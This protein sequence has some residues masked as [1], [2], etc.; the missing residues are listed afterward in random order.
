M[1]LRLPVLLLFM[2]LVS[3]A[4][5]QERNALFDTAQRHWLLGEDNSTANHPLTA[6][7]RIEWN[8][9]AEGGGANAI[10]AKLED[11]FFNAGTSPNLSGD[12]CTVYLRASDPR[13]QWGTALLAKR[14]GHDTINFNLYSLP[15]TIGFEIH[16]D[17]GGF[18]GVTFPLSDI[19]P[20]AWHDF[21]GRYDGKTVELFCDGKVMAR[22]RW[23]GGMLTQNQEPL[24]IGAET[25]AG[26]TVRPFTG[27]MEEA[28][29]W[30][31]ALSNKELAT[32]MRKDKIIKPSEPPPPY[33]S[34]IHFRPKVGVLADTIPFFWKG[35]YHIFYLHGPMAK[36]PWEHVVS[37]DLVHWQELPT[38]LRPDGDASGPD[39]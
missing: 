4:F 6:H 14:G 1:R 24:L 21:V 12:Q 26:R 17:I 11:A 3:S 19:V 16:T 33:A 23:P 15:G 27:E 39:G 38:A 31:R 18:V 8:V 37:A 5:G 28:A 2:S 32:L 22:T 7:G 13:G 9:K 20:T 30:S 29:I 25:D 35:E 36:V 10:V 34:P